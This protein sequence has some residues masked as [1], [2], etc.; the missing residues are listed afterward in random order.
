[1]PVDPTGRDLKQFLAD[2][3]GGPVVMLNL[4]RFKADAR[5]SYEEYVRQIRPFLDEI[6][7]EVVYAG[8]CSS[9]LVACSSVMPQS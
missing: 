2:D 9:V 4:M 5:E 6:A 1:M 8:D 7:A 3:P